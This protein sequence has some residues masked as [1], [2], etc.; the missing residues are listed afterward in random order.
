MYSCAVALSL[1]SKDQGGRHTPVTSGFRSG[2]HFGGYGR[3]AVFE[4]DENY[5]FPGGSV[6]AIMTLL[7]HSDKERCE[8]ERLG[9]VDVAN[10]DQL[11]GVAVL[12]PP[13]ATAG[14]R[15]K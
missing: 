2:V 7:L 11:I 13:V 9:S 6:E 12:R 15:D 1:L 4:F 5:L 10:A 8:L 14:S 3:I